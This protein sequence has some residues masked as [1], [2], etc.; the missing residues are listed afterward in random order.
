MIFCLYNISH[1]YTAI[2]P[3][4]IIK[5]FLIGVF[6]STLIKNFLKSEGC[7]V[8]YIKSSL[9][10]TLS[11]VGI[12]TCSFSIAQTIMLGKFF[13]NSL[14]LPCSIF[15]SSTA[16]LSSCIFLILNLMHS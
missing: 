12:I 13:M 3:P 6:L 5:A 2:L 11:P 4:P 1:R 14:I 16:Y 15:I 7:P 10:I 9:E 8:I